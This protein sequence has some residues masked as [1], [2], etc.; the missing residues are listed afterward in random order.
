V[1]RTG[2][3]RLGG[4][5]PIVGGIFYVTLGFM[6]WLCTPNCPRSSGYVVLAFFDLLVFGAMVALASLHAVQRQRYGLLGDPCVIALRRADETVVARFTKFVDPE[7]I[8]RAAEED[9]RGPFGQGESAPLKG[10]SLAPWSGRPLGR[11]FA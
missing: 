10:A 6:T 9:H 3:I 11:S 7:E 1:T 4:L 8:R 5:V 2:L